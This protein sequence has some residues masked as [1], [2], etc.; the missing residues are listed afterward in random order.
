M[1]LFTIVPVLAFIIIGVAFVG[2]IKGACEQSKLNKAIKNAASHPDA[3]K[4][5]ANNPNW[6]NSANNEWLHQMQMNDAM[7]MHR[8]AHND[9]MHLHDIAHTTAIN[10]HM[11]FSTINQMHHHM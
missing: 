11:D 6:N 9:A 1:F 7:N 2:L 8:M 5:I 4:N 10:N 3:L